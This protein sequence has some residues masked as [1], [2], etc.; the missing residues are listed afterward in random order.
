LFAAACALLGSAA[1]VAGQGLTGTAYAQQGQ[2]WGQGASAR[3]GSDVHQL[4]AELGLNDEQKAAYRAMLTGIRDD[5]GPTGTALR[6]S[7]FELLA[8]VVAE[9]PPQA[10]TLHAQLD[11]R[12]EAQRERAHC[13][14]DHTLGF[15]Q[16]LSAAQR[17][18]ISGHIEQTQQRRQQ[19]MQA[20]GQ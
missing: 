4:L 20:W 18:T 19:W 5:C 7:T 16:T 14:L 17:A 15:S 2:G 9:E 11:E 1:T 8:A 6:G 3:Q 10:A 12:I 13:V